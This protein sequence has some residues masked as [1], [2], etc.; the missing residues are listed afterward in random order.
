MRTRCGTKH[1]QRLL[2]LHLSRR[3]Q[4]PFQSLPVKKTEPNSVKASVEIHARCQHAAQNTFRL[5]DCRTTRSL[6]SKRGVAVCVT[7]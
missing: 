4:L 1:P 7:L 3:V 6:L 2:Q 5:R